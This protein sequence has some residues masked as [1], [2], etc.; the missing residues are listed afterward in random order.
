[1]RIFVSA[2]MEGVAGV[3]HVD[4]TR[5]TGKDYE[6]ARLWM[7]REVNAAIG[8]A[9]DGGAKAVLVNDS[10]GDMRNFVLEELDARVELISGSLKPLSMVQGVD[11]G[12]DAAFFVGY[13]AGASSRHGILDHTYYGLVV[14]EVK[15][16][17][18]P[19]NETALNALVAGSHGV[20]VALVT[21]DEATCAQA[22]EV[23]GD[24]QTVAV[25]SAVSR[26][27]ARSLH[28]EEACRRIRDGAR[29]A[30]GRISTLRPFVVAPPL[31]LEVA[32]HN[33]AMAD[34][35]ELLPDTKRVDGVRCSYRADEPGRMLRVLLAWTHLAASTVPT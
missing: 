24:I 28:P 19:F 17:G 8:G 31:D 12:Y 20:P 6:R 33:A 35:A 10:H 11:G 23:L 13:H 21:G 9:Y 26:Y 5:R 30:M 18:R 4:Q 25:K 15:V 32:F 14:H 16:G 29:T 1:M 27:S 34:A 2:D 3:L 22:R 7:T